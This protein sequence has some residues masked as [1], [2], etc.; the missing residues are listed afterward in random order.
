MRSQQQA[1]RAEQQRIKSLVLNYDLT[2]DQH[3]GEEPSFHY[4]QSPHGTRTRL[5]GR[6]TLNQSLKSRGN[7][8]GQ[9]QHQTNMNPP[10]N[11]AN[12]GS[13]RRKSH[14]SGYSSPPPLP[15]FTV[16]NIPPSDLQADSTTE[17]A[18]DNPHSQPRL[19]KSGNTRSKQRSRKLQLGDIDWYGR[20]STS[21]FAVTPPPA[22]TSLDAF[23]VDQETGRGSLRGRG[24]GSTRGRGLNA[25]QHGDR[26]NNAG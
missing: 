26:N 12:D 2:D 7:Q 15:T 21:A 4:V 6:G 14:D 24:R 25:S 10:S 18:F 5:V 19:D 20:R 16:P 8:V 17:G 11:P 22:Q 23:V 1:E 3:D 9:S 13:I